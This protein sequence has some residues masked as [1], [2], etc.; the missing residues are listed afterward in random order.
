MWNKAINKIQSVV[1]LANLI[2]KYVLLFITYNYN[3]LITKHAFSK[4]QKKKLG[5][6]LFANLETLTKKSFF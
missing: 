6:F 3:Y 2:P 4:L 1:S 5:N